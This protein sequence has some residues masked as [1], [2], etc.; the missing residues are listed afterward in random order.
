VNGGLCRLAGGHLVKLMWV[1]ESGAEN[2]LNAVMVKC[3]LRKSVMGTT[4][5]IILRK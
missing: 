2:M 1:A 5:K 3:R 4:R